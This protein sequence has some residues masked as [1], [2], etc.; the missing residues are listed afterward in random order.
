MDSDLHPLPRVTRR[1][2]SDE[3]PSPATLYRWTS[4]GVAG[5][6]LPVTKVGRRSFISEATFRQWL[7]DVTAAKQCA[8]SGAI[9]PAVEA[10]LVEAGLMESPKVGSGTAG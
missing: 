7:Q 4:K 1:V 6:K 2:L 3:A 5:V 8:P 10:K 9:S